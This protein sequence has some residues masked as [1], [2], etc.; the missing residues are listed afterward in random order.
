MRRGV[1]KTKQVIAGI[2]SA[3]LFMT[4]LPQNSTYVYATE[5][6]EELITN[7]TMQ[8]QNETEEIT[9]GQTELTVDEAK[10][11]K[12]KKKKQRK[13]KKNQL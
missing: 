4:S 13:Q 2:L 3:V 10:Q 11:K 7:E 9:D 12:V 1:R 5:Q 6:A 8:I